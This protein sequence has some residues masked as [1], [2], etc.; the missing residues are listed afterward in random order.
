L[1]HYA[2]DGSYKEIFDRYVQ[3]DEFTDPNTRK[4]L[5]R[6]YFRSLEPEKL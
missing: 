4:K 3:I 5:V 2:K 6:F 1:G